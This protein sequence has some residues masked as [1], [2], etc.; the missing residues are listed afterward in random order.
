MSF[1]VYF[2]RFRDGDA[3][4]GGGERMR[5]VLD[6]FIGREEPE[7]SFLLVDYHDGSADVYLDGDSM[8]AN[9]ITGQKPWELLVEGARAAEWVIMPVGCP[10]CL[11]DEAQHIH[12]PESLNKDVALV[13]TG[14][15]LLHVIRSC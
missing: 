7:H 2:Q 14:E 15:E 13:R 9:H 3:E 12:L 8:M 10:T 4:P 5:E 1:D 6:R 11:T